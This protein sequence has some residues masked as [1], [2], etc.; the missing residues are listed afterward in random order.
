[1]SLNQYSA[2]DAAVAVL[3]LWEDR[4]ENCKVSGN[5]LRVIGRE[6]ESS[7]VEGDSPVLVI[8]KCCVISPE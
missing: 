8:R 5:Y 6:L 7:T 4:L 3:G 2:K 1:M